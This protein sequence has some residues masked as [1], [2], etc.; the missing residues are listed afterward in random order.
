M[1][2]EIDRG[3]ALVT[4]SGSGIGRTIAVGL[5]SSGFPVVVNDI[6]E[7]TGNQVVAEITANG[8][9]AHF[10]AAD[11]SR[12]DQVKDLFD[13]ADKVFGVPSVLVNNA[14]TPG[15]F[16]LLMDMEDTDWQ[17]N[18]SV[19]IDG[20]F[21]CLREAAR[22]MS[23][24][25]G[26]IVNIASIAGIDGTVGSAAYA[27]AK[28]AVINLSKTAAKELGA[29]GITVNAIA[30]GM[31]ATPIN[32]KLADQGSSFI[33]SAL[34]G[35]PTGNMTDPGEIAALVVFLCTQGKSINGQVIAMDGGASITANIDLF[36][37]SYLGNTKKDDFR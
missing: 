14:G 1:G 26:Q 28:A 29:N 22:R 6:N 8:G 27:A 33:T 11:I 24:N 17:K 30:P 36:M 31:V 25:G 37:L 3:F 19:H 35:V 7:D 23:G 20:T 9:R 18:I 32:Q 21:Y 12:V 34:E 2:T 13:E 5:A 15:K 16:S 4:G 10:V